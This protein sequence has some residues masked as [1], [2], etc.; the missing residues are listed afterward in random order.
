MKSVFS[1]RSP[2]WMSGGN[3]A[4]SLSLE[5]DIARNPTVFGKI[6]RGELPSTRVYEDADVV[7]FADIHPASK[8]HYLVIP[9]RRIKTV[10]WLEPGDRALVEKLV[11]VGHRVAREQCGLGRARYVGNWLQQGQQEEE[12]PQQ[13]RYS[14]GFHKPPLITVYHLHLHVIA[15]LPCKNWWYRL[16]FPTLTY[17]WLYVSP[18]SVLAKLGP[19]SPAPASADDVAS[20]QQQ[21]QQG[22]ARL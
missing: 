13:D 10:N 9:R 6:L 8:H 19:A 18:E 22:G 14:L 11:A 15:P 4:L 1:E 17:G 16:I 5:D 20:Q 2:F 21:Q 3:A 12:D 7:A